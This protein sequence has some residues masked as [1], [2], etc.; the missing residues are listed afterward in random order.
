MNSRDVVEIDVENVTNND[1]VDGNDD[2]NVEKILY[3]INPVVAASSSSENLNYKVYYKI[4]ST[5]LIYK[6]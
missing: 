1:S 5:I 3:S 4:N 2:V 6:F